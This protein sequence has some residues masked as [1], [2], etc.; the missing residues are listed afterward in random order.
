MELTRATADSFG[1]GVGPNPAARLECGR[2][3]LR[4]GRTPDAERLLR[5]AVRL[6]PSNQEIHYQLGIALQRNGN[7]A[8]AEQHLKRFREIEQDLIDL[9]DA[10]TAMTKSTN[11]PA[12]RVQA[13]RICLR[14]GQDQEGLRWLHGALQVNPSYGP[15]HAALAEY[16]ERHGDSDRAAMHRR[17]ARAR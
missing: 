5:E 2:T 3:A 16:Y 6:S 1:G 8:E 11:D 17:A 15:A 4:E 13:G 7:A 14:N 9:E 12:P 10:V